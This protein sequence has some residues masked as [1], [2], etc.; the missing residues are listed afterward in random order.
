[1]LDTINNA[2]L[3]RHFQRRDW[4][5]LDDGTILLEE[6]ELDLRAGR[7]NVTWTML[8][9]DGRRHVQSHSLRVYT[10]VEFE[11]MLASAGLALWRVWR[12]FEGEPYGPD[13]QRMILLAERL[14]TSGPLARPLA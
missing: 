11:T 7:N 10:L 4:T 1:M 9:P 2:W 14:K 6:R 8:Y 13:T 3:M 5:S 12:N